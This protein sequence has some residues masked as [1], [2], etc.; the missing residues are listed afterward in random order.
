MQSIFIH[1]FYNNKT[2]YPGGGGGTRP[3]N[4]C[5]GSLPPGSNPCSYLYVK[6]RGQNATLSEN[7]GVK[8]YIQ[9]KYMSQNSTFRKFWDQNSTLRENIGQNST[10]ASYMNQASKTCVIPHHIWNI[11]VI[12][13]TRLKMRSYVRPC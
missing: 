13:R 5:I 3:Q 1:M 8:L 6:H 12:C 11:G 10:G 2:S 7:I 4:G 9:I